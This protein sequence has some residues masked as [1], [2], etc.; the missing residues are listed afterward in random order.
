MEADCFQILSFLSATKPE[1]D[2]HAISPLLQREDRCLFS[3]RVVRIWKGWAKRFRYLKVVKK[4]CWRQIDSGFCESGSKEIKK[5]TLTGWLDILR[6][7]NLISLSV[8]QRRSVSF[9]RVL[10]CG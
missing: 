4:R 5:A 7:G 8:R 6:S 3:D 1:T 10:A 9:F 2:I